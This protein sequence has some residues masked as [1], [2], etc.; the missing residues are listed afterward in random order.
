MGHSAA[1]WDYRAATEITKDWNG[2]HQIVLRTPRGASAQVRA[3]FVSVLTFHKV[4]I[5]YFFVT[6]NVNP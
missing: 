6:S 5:L 2:I 3:C 1:V 4:M